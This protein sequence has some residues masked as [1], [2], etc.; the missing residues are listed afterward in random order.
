MDMELLRAHRQN[1]EMLRDVEPALRFAY[2]T[3]QAWAV[4]AGVQVQRWSELDPDVR[5][6]WMAAA[7]FCDMY[8]HIMEIDTIVRAL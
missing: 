3:Y 8:K 7:D 5:A 6:G 4:G 1:M 2:A